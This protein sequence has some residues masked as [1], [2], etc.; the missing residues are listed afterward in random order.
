MRSWKSFSGTT[1][2]YPKEIETNLKPLNRQDPAFREK[3]KDLE[4]HYMSRIH[5]FTEVYK[6][7]VDTIKSDTYKLLACSYLDKMDPDLL[8]P[9]R[10][11]RFTFV[12]ETEEP[13][14]EN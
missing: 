6:L 5:L 8:S 3:Y 10:E 14:E 4:R 12:Y 7:L 11:F 2:S 9:T 1:E 13:K